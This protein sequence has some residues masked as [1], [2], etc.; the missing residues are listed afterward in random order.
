M[1]CTGCDGLRGRHNKYGC[2]TL[3]MWQ[4]CLL[5][6]SFLVLLCS[7]SLLLRSQLRLLLLLREAG[8]WCKLDQKRKSTDLKKP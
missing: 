1:G 7:G 4:L 5:L 8:Q 3:F 6:Q 2:F